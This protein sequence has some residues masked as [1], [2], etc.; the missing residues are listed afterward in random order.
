MSGGFRSIFG[1][2]VGGISSN[3]SQQ[4]K[5]G[6]RSFLAPWMGGL[7]APASGHNGGYKSLLGFWFGGLQSR[8]RESSNELFSTYVWW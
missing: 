6:F 2:W 4:E 8:K 3:P 7:S 5:G 1:K